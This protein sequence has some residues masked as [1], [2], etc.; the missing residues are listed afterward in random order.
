MGWEKLDVDSE[1]AA[2][3]SRGLHSK[4]KSLPS[5][6]SLITKEQFELITTD[7]ER[8]VIIKVLQVQVKLRLPFIAWPGFFMK[9]TPMLKPKKLV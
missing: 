1:I 8:P 4:S 2:H 3:R 9:K 6:L 5:I 7:P